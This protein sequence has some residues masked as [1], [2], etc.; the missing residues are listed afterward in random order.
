MP[1]C[2][3]CNYKCDTLYH[4]REHQFIH[5]RER[6]KC[7]ECGKTFSNNINLGAHKRKVH[8]KPCLF[9]ARYKNAQ[10]ECAAC[11]R[12]LRK[13]EKHMRAHL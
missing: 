3:K 12:I 7:D 6:P 10:V 9:L 8:P 5:S 4:L 2:I 13:I 11:K 1:V